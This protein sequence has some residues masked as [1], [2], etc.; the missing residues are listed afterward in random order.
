MKSYEYSINPCDVNKLSKSKLVIFDDTFTLILF[1]LYFR[2]TDY[3]YDE[4]K[5]GRISTKSEGR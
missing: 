2:L 5:Y 4:S 1:F 3:R